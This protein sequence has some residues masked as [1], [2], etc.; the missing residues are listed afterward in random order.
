MNIPN[1]TLDEELTTEQQ[2][3]RRQVSATRSSDIAMAYKVHRYDRQSQKLDFDQ[4][5]FDIAL[6]IN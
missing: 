4:V 1:Y 2:F 5:L 6:K 3:F